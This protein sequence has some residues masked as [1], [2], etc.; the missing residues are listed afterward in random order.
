[1]TPTKNYPGRTTAE[2]ICDLTAHAEALIE[3]LYHENG[4]LLR[5]DAAA[6]GEAMRLHE[7][8]ARL[9][10]I[11]RLLSRSGEAD[12]DDHAFIDRRR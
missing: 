10:V 11:A 4:E 6:H 1:M 8:I 12:R 9:E 7:I 5:L 2:L 3:R